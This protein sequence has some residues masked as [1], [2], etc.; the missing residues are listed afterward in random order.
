MEDRGRIAPAK[1][2][3][4]RVQGDDEYIPLSWWKAV[5]EFGDLSFALVE[6]ERDVFSSGD[7]NFDSFAG[8]S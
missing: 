3:T 8:N 4:E 5:S 6:D 1:E 7:I 2:V